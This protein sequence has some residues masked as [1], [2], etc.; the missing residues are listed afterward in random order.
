MNFCLAQDWQK[1]Y[2]PLCE[3]TIKTEIKAFS[4]K[5]EKLRNLFSRKLG[6][7][8]P[9]SLSFQSFVFSGDS[10]RAN[11]GSYQKEND[12]RAVLGEQIFRLNQAKYFILNTN[13]AQYRLRITVVSYPLIIR[14]YLHI[15]QDS[16]MEQH[17]HIHPK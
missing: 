3:S 12:R 1:Y 15:H 7:Y 11:Q 5:T 6:Y 14:R 10:F 2:N 17:H 9:H 4:F 8:F 16:Q 13:E